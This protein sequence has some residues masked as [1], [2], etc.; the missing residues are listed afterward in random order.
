MTADNTTGADGQAPVVRRRG[1]GAVAGAVKGAVL[2]ALAVVILRNAWVCDD[3]YITLRTVDNFVHGLGLRWNTYERVQAY[4][5]PLWMFLLAWAYSLT[6]ESYFTTIFLAVA[7]SLGAVALAVWRFGRT[8][9]AALFLVVVLAS[10]KAFMDYTTS[11]LE[12]PLT[13][14]LVVVFVW[15]Y[16]EQTWTPRRLFGL[17]LVAALAGLNRLDLLAIFLPPLAYAAF[18]TGWRRSLKPLA[19]GLAPLVAWE[20]F[21]LLYY[22]FPVPNTAYAK[23]GTGVGA[24][25]LAGQGLVYFADSLVHDPLTLIVVAAGVVAALAT[26]KGAPAAAAAGVVLYLLYVV[27]VGGDFMSGRFF[28]S[29]VLLASVLIV[30]SVTTRPAAW[31]VLAAVAAVLGMVGGGALMTG[32]ARSSMGA[33]M[34]DAYIRNTGIADERRV[35]CPDTGLLR[36]LEGRPMPAHKWA[37]RGRHRRVKAPTV[38]VTGSI[39]FVGFFAGP[40]QVTIDLS[41]LADPLLARLPPVSA[42]GGWRVGHFVRTLP[43]GYRESVRTGQNK[44]RDKDLAEY[45]D[46]LCLVTRGRLLDPARLL[47]IV[48]FNLGLNDHLLESYT[49]QKPVYA[50]PQEIHRSAGQGGVPF[51]SAGVEVLLGT[52]RYDHAVEV[53][54]EYGSYCFIPCRWGRGIHCLYLFTIPQDGARATWRIDMPWPQVLRGYDSLLIVPI[55]EDTPHTIDSVRLLGDIAREH[56]AATAAAASQTAG[57]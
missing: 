9:A 35:Y 49:R 11:G 1:R 42:R 24:M 47:E 17:S 13:Y 56:A 32:G 20:L 41:A 43:P 36:A 3:A 16:L 14:L 18:K 10:S 31:A 28:S 53:R 51:G 34:P 19:A 50:T 37:Q 30:T 54:L 48:R 52:L 23:L 12:N 15:L 27:R 4:T 2:V 25:E 39:G 38:E 21:A 46:R 6:R 29:L 22:G 55:I 45:Y 26:R 8:T 5:H 33:L 7:A 57:S 40:K 44:I